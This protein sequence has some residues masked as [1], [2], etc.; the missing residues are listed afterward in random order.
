MCVLKNTN[1]LTE[2]T[3][4]ITNCYNELTATI[5]NDYND[6]TTPITNY[7]LSPIAMLSA[8]T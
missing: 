3:N 5:K 6:L 1:I 2:Q 8:R 7:G 4:L